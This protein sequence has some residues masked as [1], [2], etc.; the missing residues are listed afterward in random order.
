MMLE[1]VGS[2]MQNKGK[3]FLDMTSK[4]DLELDK[5]DFIKIL[6]FCSFK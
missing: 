1:K 5:L 6:N 3:D 2:H 4:H